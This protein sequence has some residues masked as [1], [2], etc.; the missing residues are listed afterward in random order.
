MATQLCNLASRCQR[1][2]PCPAQPRV[3]TRV[4]I[5]FHGRDRRFRKLL[6]SAFTCTRDD[7]LV[8]FWAGENPTNDSDVAL[9]IS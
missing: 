1:S 8:R 6:L 3:T 4:D 2:A 5:E 7:S 9:I